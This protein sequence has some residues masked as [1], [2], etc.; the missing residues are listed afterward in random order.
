MISRF[1]DADLTMPKTHTTTPRA[2]GYRMPGEFEP[3][4]GCWM[5]WPERGD[6]WRLGAEPARDAFTAVA[7]A[8]ARFEPVTVGASRGQ[9]EIARN[10]LPEA[11]RVVELS[12]ND[13]WMRDCGPTFVVDDRGG[14]R[15]VDWEFNAWGELY[16][17]WDKDEMVARKVLEMIGFDRYRAP[18]VL[19]GGAVHVDGQG[20]LLTTEECLLNPNRNPSLSKGEIEG[21]LKD[22]LNLEKV[23]WLPRGVHMDETSGHVDNLCCFVRPGVAALT[24]PDDPADPQHDISTEAL[25]VLETETDAR[26]RRF[27][28]HRIVQPGPLFMTGEESRSIETPE[29]SFPREIGERLAG[30][31]I[32]FYIANGGI[33]A[34]QF[35]DPM[36]KPA[37]EALGRLFPNRE[38]VGIPSREILLGGG[39]IHCI[40]QQQPPG[41]SK[42]TP[43]EP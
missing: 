12:S 42:E 1:A 33:V 5:L 40:T 31:Y 10:R 36:D 13:A 7:G 18:M 38:V 37:L 15:G 24:W 16:F 6:T 17:P 8:I 43:W 30:S 22:Y 23:V 19:E 27:E 9:W 39:N 14:V 32:N 2:D 34:P 29:K 41:N 20:T 35:D 28:V 11:V 21:L 4:A 26:G 25:R 3:H